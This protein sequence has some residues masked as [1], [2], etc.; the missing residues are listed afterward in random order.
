MNLYPGG[1]Q[2]HMHNTWFIHDGQKF[3]QPTIFPHKLHMQYKSD[4][5]SNLC[6]AKRILK[7]QPE[8]KAQ[9]LL[10]QEVIEELGHICIFL[11][12][13]HCELNYLNFSGEQS[14]DG[15]MKTVITPS[16]ACK[17]ICQRLWMLLHLTQFRN[18]NS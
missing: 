14:S 9:R 17:I 3:D 7:L 5:T 1:K 18:G 11:P 16:R 10:V 12:K 6:C 13:F 2:A 8:F 15:S 4:C